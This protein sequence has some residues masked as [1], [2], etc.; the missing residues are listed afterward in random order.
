MTFDIDKGINKG[1]DKDIDKALDA[2][3]DTFT[4]G[5]HQIAN[6]LEFDTYRWHH[7]DHGYIEL[8]D[9]RNN[10]PEQMSEEEWYRNCVG[11]ILRILRMWD[12]G[13]SMKVGLLAVLRLLQNDKDHQAITESY[14]DFLYADDDS[15]HEEIVNSLDSIAEACGVLQSQHRATEYEGDWS[16]P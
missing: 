2:I 14:I 5:P 9:A 1:I 10:R 12:K 13:M 7:V 8:L 6:D 3:D 16:W 15:D 11:H 4:W